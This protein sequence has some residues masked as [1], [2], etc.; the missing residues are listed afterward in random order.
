MW[1]PDGKTVYYSSNTQGPMHIYA[2]SADGT[3]EERAVLGGTD[4][5]AVPRSISPDGKYLAYTRQL[6]TGRR[7]SVEIWALPLS[8]DG[9]PFP[10]VQNNFNSSRPVVSPDGKW[11][12]YSNT[13]TG[14]E[15]IYITAFPGG[16]AKWQVSTNGGSQSQWPK[17]GRELFFLDPSNNL[18]A[19]DVNTT[20]NTVKLGIPHVLFKLPGVNQYFWYAVNADGKKFVF[21]IVNSRGASEPLT[22]VQNWTADLKK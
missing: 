4:E 16:G 17:D 12:A 13:E 3:G 15:E 14:R 10:I 8:G 2:K 9:K 6:G 21:D 19:V 22:L 7:N 11:M 1:T 5:L 20:N 18:M